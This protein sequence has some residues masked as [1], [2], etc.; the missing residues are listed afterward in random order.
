LLNLPIHR[1][2]VTPFGDMYGG[3]KN[4]L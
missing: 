1:S 2:F 3:L 4:G